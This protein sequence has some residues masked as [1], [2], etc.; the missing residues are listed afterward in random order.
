LL[1][2]N[3]DAAHRYLVRGVSGSDDRPKGGSGTADRPDRRHQSL[4]KRLGISNVARIWK[5]W[6]IKPFKQET[7]K[8]CGGQAISAARPAGDHRWTPASA[9]I[10]S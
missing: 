6:G 5:R 4:A 10:D 9:P 8:F 1:T 2:D 3:P 7:F